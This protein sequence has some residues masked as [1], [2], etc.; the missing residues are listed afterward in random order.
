MV[1]KKVKVKIAGITNIEDAR[2]AIKA[3]CDALGFIFFKKSPRYIAPEK[4][5]EI[6]RQLPKGVITIGVFCGAK[7][8]EIKK[9]AKQCALDALQ[10]HGGESAAFCRKFKNYKIIK[11]FRIKD[12]IDVNTIKK[13]NTFACL[14]DTYAKSKGRHR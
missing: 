3:G 13:Y 7:E 4:A 11:V 5:S 8:A 10:F 6:I 2:A 9:I 12:T 1:E 14:F